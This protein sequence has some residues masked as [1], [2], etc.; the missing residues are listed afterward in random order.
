MNHTE[1]LEQMLKNL[2]R[3]RHLPKYQLERRADVFFGLFVK[4][5]MEAR[6]GRLNEVV[7]PEFPYK[8]DSN[9]KTTVNFDYVLFSADLSRVFVVELKTEPDSAG[10][11]NNSYLNEVVDLPFDK[12]IGDLKAVVAAT[13]QKA[14]Y[15]CLIG[16]L[17]ETG[18]ILKDSDDGNSWDCHPKIGK[19]TVVYLTP[20]LKKSLNKNFELIF[21]DE[22]ADILEKTGGAV[23]CHFASYLRRWNE[24]QAGSTGN[25]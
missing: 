8:N 4:L 12:I 11:A 18:L 21:F 25:E 5:I 3:W 19:P 6:F 2:D 17:K 22:A 23:E 15:N 9:R 24:V 13:R 1:A 14:K 10:E 7:I 20:R 16:Q